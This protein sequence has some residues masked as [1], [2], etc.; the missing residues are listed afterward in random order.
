MLEGLFKRKNTPPNLTARAQIVLG[1]SRKGFVTMFGVIQPIS[2]SVTLTLQEGERGRRFR[3]EL[4]PLQKF[5]CLHLRSAWQE[6]WILAAAYNLEIPDYP[7]LAAGGKVRS[8]P[9]LLPTWLGVTEDTGR[10]KG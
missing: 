7:L 4:L 3:F 10:I 5:M 8:S 9:T 1:H 6:I 2:E